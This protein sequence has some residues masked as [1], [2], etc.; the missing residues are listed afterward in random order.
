MDFSGCVDDD[1]F[2]PAIHGCRDNF[3]FT[4][5]FENIFLSIIP[6]SLFI[7][8]ALGRIIIL[9]RQPEAVSGS[10]LR[11]VKLAA[12]NAYSALQLSLLIFSTDST[13]PR[14]YW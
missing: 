1:S 6:A 12:T 5:K 13:K 4:I 11:G 9:G 10:I 8:V 14:R 7:V 3:D 2:G